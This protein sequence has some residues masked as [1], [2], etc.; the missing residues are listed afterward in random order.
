MQNR[1][2]IRGK[3]SRSVFHIFRRSDDLVKCDVSIK[4]DENV[5]DI[6]INVYFLQFVE[7]F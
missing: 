4:T 7:I 6:F 1:I 5:A 2:Q 3:T